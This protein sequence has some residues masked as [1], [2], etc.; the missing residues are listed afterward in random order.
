MAEHLPGPP[1]RLLR[2]PTPRGA[3]NDAG[4]PID[5]NVARQGEALI[6]VHVGDLEVDAA[7]SDLDAE[8]RWVRRLVPRLEPDLWS[9]ELCS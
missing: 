1:S 6:R 5:A 2:L 4:Q 8:S 7:A 3:I 9:C